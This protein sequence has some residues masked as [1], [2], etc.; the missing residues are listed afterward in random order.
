V[1]DYVR[2]RSTVS[3]RLPTHDEADALARA[4]G[5][6]VLVV[7]FT[8]TDRDGVPVEAGRTLFAADAVQLV[9]EHGA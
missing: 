8:S 4:A 6:P 1:H 5:E 2:A 3:C 7:G 9:V